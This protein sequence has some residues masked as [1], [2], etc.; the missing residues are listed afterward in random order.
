[1]SDINIDELL[2][3]SLDD[4]NDLPEFK[5]FPAGSHLIKM[6]MDKKEVNEKPCVEIKLVMVETVELAKEV[7]EDKKCVE[8]DETSSLCVLTN[9]YGQ[10]NLKAICKPIGE[11][12]GTSNLSEIVASV[13]D[14]EC[15]VTTTLRK[16][17]N[18]PDK[19]YTQIKQ[20][21]LG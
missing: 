6:T 15:A 4:L 1:M 9:E 21:T 18:D 3:I 2:D 11:A 17:K 7:S 16:D 19:F 13:K 20:V 10:G 8:C 14:L 12:L 5:P